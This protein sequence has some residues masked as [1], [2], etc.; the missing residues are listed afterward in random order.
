MKCLN[1]RLRYTDSEG[2]E[3]TFDRGDQYL[4]SYL[5]RCLILLGHTH[6]SQLD[7]CLEDY[8]EVIEKGGSD[9]PAGD[10]PCLPEV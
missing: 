9:D 4:V 8:L 2:N 5:R 6:E 10:V 3:Q 7:G 1:L